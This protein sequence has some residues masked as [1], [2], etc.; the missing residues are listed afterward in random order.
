MTSR[1]LWPAPEAV[2]EAA[3]S[4]SMAVTAKKRLRAAMCCSRSTKKRN[5]VFRTK[6]RLLRRFITNICPVH[7]L[8]RQ[9]N[10]CTAI[11][12]HGRC[13]RQESTFNQLYRKALA[14]RSTLC[15]GFCDLQGPY[16]AQRHRHVNAAA[17]K[18]KTAR[19][20]ETSGL[21]WW[22]RRGSNS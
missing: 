4:R 22:R 16:F 15:E 17:V 19:F 20:N 11:I 18:N 6:T 13:R 1:R 8:N 7:A 3:V 10:C 21:I 5:F 12:L 14:E 2:Q 9:K